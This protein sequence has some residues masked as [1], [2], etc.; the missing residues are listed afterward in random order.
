MV[1]SFSRM[2]FV[3]FFPAQSLE[4]FLAG[5]LH[6][7][8]YFQGV[9]KKIR[10]DNLKS[11]VFTRIGPTIQFNR[12]FLDFARYYCSIPLL[13]NRISLTKKD[14]WKMRRVM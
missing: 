7:F 9:A 8:H 13:C 3:E 11:V 1:L 10:Y 2:L 5:H 14:A 12:R 4:N 6:A